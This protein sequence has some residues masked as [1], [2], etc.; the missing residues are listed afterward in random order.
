MNPPLRESGDHFSAFRAQSLYVRMINDILLLFTGMLKRSG[1]GA[2][3][4]GR[5][6][7]TF[8]NRGEKDAEDQ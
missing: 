6:Q 5:M 4:V 1:R 7:I 2:V 8:V 3:A